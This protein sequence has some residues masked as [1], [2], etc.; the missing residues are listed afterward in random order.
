MALPGLNSVKLLG[1]FMVALIPPQD[2]GGQQIWR[3]RLITAL[4]VGG[5]ALGLGIHIAWAC[6]LLAGIGLNGFASAADVNNV[7]SQLLTIEQGQLRSE[8]LSTRAVQCRAASQ[9]AKGQDDATLSFITRDL[10]EALD[11]YRELAH[12]PYQLPDCTSL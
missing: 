4:T 7:Q 8:I 2:A 11:K 5:T 9:A 6:G 1:D 10:Q 12:R 3:W